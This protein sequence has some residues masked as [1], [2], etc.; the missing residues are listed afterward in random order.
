MG[1]SAGSKVYGIEV[2]FL[3][4][5]EAF[6]FWYSKMPSYRMKKIDAMKVE[7]GKLLSLGAGILLEK[8]L[9]EFGVRGAE[10]ALSANKKPYINGADS[11]YF[12]L[13]HSG[14]MAV[15][16][17][18]DSEV[19]IDVE[20]IKVFK[21]NLIEYVFDKREIEYIRSLEN[22]D[23]EKNALYTGLWTMKES[24]M[25]YSGKGIAMV[26]KSIFVDLAKGAGGGS[27]DIYHEDK[28]IDNLHLTT[29]VV[30]GYE[31]YKICVC[32]EYDTFSE[33][34]ELFKTP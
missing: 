33:T 4:D 9:E 26:P 24:I 2:S 17:F 10:I 30:P 1:T 23:D 32:S 6:D 15:C 21:D 28:K 12:N 31:E 19:G 20:K 7:N 3:K 22:H 18:S 34:V 16:A 13:S 27:L 25:K 14:S 29:Y 8:G 11:L 5:R